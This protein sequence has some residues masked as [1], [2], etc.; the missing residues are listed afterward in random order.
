MDAGGCQRTLPCL[1]LSPREEF[2]EEVR[3]AGGAGRVYGLEMGCL[4]KR[5]QQDPDVEPEHPLVFPPYTHVS[6]FWG[7]HPKFGSLN[8]GFMPCP[9]RMAACFLGG[10]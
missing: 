5:A 7:W 4:E 2:C 10:V 6:S 1:R 3:H 9:D 8:A